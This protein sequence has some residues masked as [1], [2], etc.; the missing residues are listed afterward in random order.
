M[1]VVSKSFPGGTTVEV[2]WGAFAFAAA[3]LMCMVLASRLA[4]HGVVAPR[5]AGA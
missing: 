1:V 3:A 4:S 5:A 2:R